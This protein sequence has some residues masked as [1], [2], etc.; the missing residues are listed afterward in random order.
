MMHR[1]TEIKI[2]NFKSCRETFLK[3]ESFTALVGYN[4]AGKSNLLK[5]IDALVRGKAQDENSFY[6]PRVCPHLALHQIN[7]QAIRIIDL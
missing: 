4:N 7:I 5:C 6:D 3:L 1:I 2:S